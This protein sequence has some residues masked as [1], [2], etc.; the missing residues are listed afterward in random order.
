MQVATLCRQD[1][2]SDEMAD[3]SQADRWDPPGELKNIHASSRVREGIFSNPLRR[4]PSSG[5]AWQRPSA[6]CIGLEAHSRTASGQLRQLCELSI[7]IAQRLS[8]NAEL[9]Q[10]RQ[11]KIRHRRVF[12]IDKMTAPLEPHG[13]SAQKQ[14]G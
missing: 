5:S 1:T 7:A 14:G 6:S 10:H 3:S 12:R 13:A 2:W 9:V 4:P 11:L 8:G